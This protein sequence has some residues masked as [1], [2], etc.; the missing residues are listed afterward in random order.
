MYKHYNTQGE[1]IK[2]DIKAMALLKQIEKPIYLV[3]RNPCFGFMLPLNVMLSN[4]YKVAQTAINKL[5]SYFT[6]P[7]RVY[8]AGN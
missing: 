3:V 6:L 8:I 7:W 4:I 2:S 1:Y 5:D